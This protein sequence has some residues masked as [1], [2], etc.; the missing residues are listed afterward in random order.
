MA[1]VVREPNRPN[2]PCSPWQEVSAVCSAGQHAQ[3]LLHVHRQ[4]IE[5]VDRLYIL[6]Q[7]GKWGREAPQPFAQQP[8]LH[9]A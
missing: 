5:G 1:R 7:R 3:V 8:S 6:H 4:E 2:P 9:V